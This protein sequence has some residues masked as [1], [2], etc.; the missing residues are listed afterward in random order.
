M[1]RIELVL[2]FERM[3]EEQ[4]KRVALFRK[5][6]AALIGARSKKPYLDRPARL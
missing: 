2:G 3:T 4:I 6:Y 5:R 1:D